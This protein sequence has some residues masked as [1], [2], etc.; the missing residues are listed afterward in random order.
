MQKHVTNRVVSVFLLLFLLLGVSVSCFWLGARVGRMY[1]TQKVLYELPRRENLLFSL[2]ET[3]GLFH[4]YSQTYQDRWV[5]YSVFP[6]VRDGFYVDIGSGD[7]VIGSNTK[8]LNDL[9]W[10]GVCVDPFPTNMEHRTCQ[11]FK[12]VVYS[13]S[14][15]RVQFRKADAFAGIEDTL[16]IWKRKADAAPVVEF[17]TVTLND[18]LARAKAPK[19]I[20]YMSIDIEGAEYEALKGLSFDQYQIGAFTIEHNWDVPKRRDIKDLLESKGY[21]LV[22]SVFQDDW[23]VQKDL[24]QKFR[25]MIQYDFTNP[26]Q[27]MF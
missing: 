1:E 27:E 15:R 17:Q 9:G 24:A 7:G 25:L 5:A 11:M 21:R 16:G 10:K 2:R 22:R 14:G 20:H 3:L 26:K 19:F 6:G 23:Y 8:L 18:I 13:E 12:E 4:A